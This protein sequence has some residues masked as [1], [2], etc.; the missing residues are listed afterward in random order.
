MSEC[1]STATACFIEVPT[2]CMLNIIDKQWEGA[3]GSL[4]TLVESS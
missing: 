3:L 4:K 1:A 2:R